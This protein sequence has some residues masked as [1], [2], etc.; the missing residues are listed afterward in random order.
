MNISITGPNEINGFQLRYAFPPKLLLHLK[1]SNKNPEVSQ[2]ISLSVVEMAAK[3][4][5]EEEGREKRADRRMQK[6]PF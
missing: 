6:S 1:E 2:A 4:G 5:G 3:W